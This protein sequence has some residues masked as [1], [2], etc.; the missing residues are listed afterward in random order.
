[1]AVYMTAAWGAGAMDDVMIAYLPIVR[2]QDALQ[3]LRH[4]PRHYI[5]EW[6]DFRRRFVANYQSLSVKSVQP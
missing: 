1:L 3:W 4:L 6:G 5:D 2:G